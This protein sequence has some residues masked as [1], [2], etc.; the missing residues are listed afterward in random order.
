VSEETQQPAT[1]ET[2]PV[3]PS[4]EPAPQ[5]DLAEEAGNAAAQVAPT[6]QKLRSLDDLDVDGEVRSKI[7]SYV[8]KAINDAV[9]KH[10][11][12]QSKRLKD[13]GYMNRSQ[14]EELL[15]QKDAEYQRRET[16][17][18]AF[19]S[20][21]GSEGLHPGSEGY[22]KVQQ[23]YVD[24]VRDGKLTPE[25]LLTEAG[26][27][28]LIAMSGANTI[29]SSAPNSGLTRSAP[30]PDG[31]VRYTDGT[32]QMNAGAAAGDTLDNRMRRALEES[33]TGK[34]S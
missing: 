21:L 30:A 25:I 8:S 5:V 22:T 31:S 9:S 26:I 1:E 23:T 28:T 4:P 18:E 14:I 33:M 27:R 19:L 3:T 15:A 24:S 32:I 11:E 20:V 10:D 7:E 2:Q 12:R 13:D 29:S 34:N 17:K 6:E 16:A